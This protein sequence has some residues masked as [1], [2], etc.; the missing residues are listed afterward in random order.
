MQTSPPWALLVRG[1][2][3]RASSSR[4]GAMRVIET[5]VV[6]SIL[7]SRKALA[8]GLAL[9]VLQKHPHREQTDTMHS[10][11]N[12]GNYINIES[13]THGPRTNTPPSLVSPNTSWLF[14]R[15]EA[16]RVGPTTPM[17]GPLWPYVYER[18]M[19]RRVFS[20]PFA[21]SGKHPPVGH[22]M[23]L[24]TQD[25]GT[26]LVTSRSGKS[27]EVAPRSATAG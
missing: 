23:A 26:E 2:R 7:P 10:I 11:A 1:Q 5:R 3:A 9:I 18:L 24:L 21:P 20:V 17:Y 4:S 12:I 8:A 16:A 27:T 19:R 22:R 13:D 14:R 25:Q 6:S 15:P